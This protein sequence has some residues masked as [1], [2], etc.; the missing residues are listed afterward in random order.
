MN[1]YKPEGSLIATAKNY[2]YISSKEG[3]ER[4]LDG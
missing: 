3:L 1:I 4:A 2:E